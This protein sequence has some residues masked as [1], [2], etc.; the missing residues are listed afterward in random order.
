M[1]GRGFGAESRMTLQAQLPAF[2]QIG[3]AATP[4]LNTVEYEARL[5]PY[6]IPYLKN[7]PFEVDPA[8][9]DAGA[10]QKA[11]SERGVRLSRYLGNSPRLRA[12]T[13]LDVARADIDGAVRV[14]SDVL[15][16]TRHPVAA[17]D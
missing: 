9:M 5:V 6:D 2:T 4:Q 3:I 7:K 14:M 11:C 12:V 1:W 17:A 8:W 10:F 13:H 15:A 16:G